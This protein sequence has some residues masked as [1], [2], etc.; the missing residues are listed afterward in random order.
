MSLW[1]R[2]RTGALTLTGVNR[3]QNKGVASKE[4][5]PGRR[6]GALHVHA[7]AVGE[8]DGE[9][10]R[11]WVLRFVPV[12]SVTGSDRTTRQQHH[13]VL[14]VRLVPHF[15]DE[16]KQSTEIERSRHF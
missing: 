6:L 8:K 9:E 12:V 3:W 4:T 11:P 7:H 1:E 13:G 15:V 16:K 10:T 14:E 2:K 5:P